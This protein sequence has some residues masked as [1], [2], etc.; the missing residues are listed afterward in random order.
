VDDLRQIL[1]GLEDAKLDYVIERS[2]ARS[3]RAA[4]TKAGI[5]RSTYYNWSQE[6]RDRLNGYAQAL[7]RR[8]KLQAEL[9]LEEAAEK[10]AQKKIAGLDSDN[11]HIQQS[12][13]TEIL[14]RTIG[15][16]LQ[17]V[18]HAGEGDEGAI[19]FEIKGLDLRKDV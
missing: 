2:K 12:A 15:R 18:K 5:P 9:R 8:R 13:A 1:D 14:D 3:N 17:Q 4:W 19:V 11:E 10:A 7:K 6:E 16:P